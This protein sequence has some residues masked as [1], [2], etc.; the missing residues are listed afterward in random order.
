MIKEQGTLK[1]NIKLFEGIVFVIG[2][3]IGSGIFLKPAVVLKNMG[4]TGGA[5]SIW[6]IGGIIY[7][8]CSTFNSRNCCIYT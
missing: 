3:V 4:S 1:R 2:F 8:M 5:I 6:I 7:N